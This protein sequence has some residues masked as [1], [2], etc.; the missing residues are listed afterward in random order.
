MKTGKME[1]ESKMSVTE[2]VLEGSRSLSAPLLRRSQTNLRKKAPSGRGGGRFLHKRDMASLPRAPPPAP[3]RP[4]LG[5]SPGGTGGTWTDVG[6]KTR[7]GEGER[8]RGSD[9]GRESHCG[10]FDNLASYKTLC[11]VKMERRKKE[12]GAG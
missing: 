12:S 11:Y 7:R 10:S 5:P 9:A 2:K 8:C 1:E 6:R 3:V 4:C